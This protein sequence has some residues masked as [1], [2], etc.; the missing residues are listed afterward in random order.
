MMYYKKKYHHNNNGDFLWNL[1]E[2]IKI[3]QK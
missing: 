1:K 2:K 3:N